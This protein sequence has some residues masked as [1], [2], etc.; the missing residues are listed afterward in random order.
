ML[1]N[2]N[3]S[4]LSHLEVYDIGD[5]GIHFRDGSSRN[6]LEDSYIHDTG[7][8]QPGFGEGVYVG[9]ANSNFNQNTNH[10]IIRKTKIGP[11]VTAE[12]LDI[13]QKTTGTI[14]EHCTF[15]GTGMSGDNYGDSFIDI[16]AE[17]KYV[18][19]KCDNVLILS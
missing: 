6:T 2:V 10:N 4:L 12:H 15:D 3:N 19:R 13:K 11:N 14:V 8:Y 9:S 17:R 7:R 18:W 16:K 5:E 1:D